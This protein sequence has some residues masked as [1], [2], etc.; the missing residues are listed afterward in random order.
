M[1]LDENVCDGCQKAM[2]SY[3]TS[4]GMIWDL[5]EE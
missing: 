5:E 1:E 2:K 4:E 3:W